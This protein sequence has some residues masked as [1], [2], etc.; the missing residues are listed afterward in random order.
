MLQ[1]YRHPL[2][3]RRNTIVYSQGGSAEGVYF[4]C[5]GTIKLLWVTEDGEQRI[6]GFITAGE[7][8]GLDSLI[9]GSTRVFTAVT[10]NI[11]N[12]GTLRRASYGPTF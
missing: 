2:C 4:L 5:Q 8:F 11:A 6:V 12:N 3:L 10:Q 9:P 1:S 7:I